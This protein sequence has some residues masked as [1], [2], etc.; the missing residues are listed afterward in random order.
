MPQKIIKTELETKSEV[1]II[2]PIGAKI[3][4]IQQERGCVQMWSLVNAEATINE[5]HRIRSV[6]TE[7]VFP[8]SKNMKYLGTV[9]M[10]NSSVVLHYFEIDPPSES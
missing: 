1:V 2:L 10:Y 3:L 5:S 9:Q 8:D 7:R 4:S 6:A